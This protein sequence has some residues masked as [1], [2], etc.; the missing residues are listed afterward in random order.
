M[1][2][3]R[4]LYDLSR[5]EPGSASMP[6][7]HG[8]WVLI[9]PSLV[10]MAAGPTQNTADLIGLILIGGCVLGT[11]LV[12]GLRW[13]VRAIEQN[14]RR[15]ES[16]VAQRTAELRESKRQL[17]I[18]VEQ[19][20]HAEAELA[21]RAEQ[22]LHQSEERFRA[23]FESSAIGM[24]LMSLD[25]HFLKANA[26]IRKMSGYAD[27]ELRRL[28]A[29][30]IV[31]PDDLTVGLDLFAEMM[32]GQRDYYQVERRYVRKNGEVFWTRLTLSAV[33][34]KAGAPVYL[35]A[36]VEDID[37][38]K[39]TLL[40]LRKS[41]ARFQAM[42]EN[43]AVGIA[44]ISLDGR[45]LA[46]NPATQQISGYS[47][48]DLTSIN[49]WLLTA[50]EDRGLD[51]ELFA[52]LI[53]GRR[54]SYVVEMRFR[55]KTQG[56][57]WVRV[58]YSL[59][60]DPDGRPDYLIALIENIDEE[61]HAAEKLAAQETEY[62]RELEQRIAARTAELNEANRLLAQQAAQDAVNR[63]RTR[64]A[65]DLHDAVTQTLF[66]ASL[67]A[68]VLPDLWN[69]NQGE[70]LRRLEE[71][72][73]STRG[74]LAEMRTLLVELRPNALVDVPLPDLLRQLTES[75]IGRA[76]LPVQLT[77][78]GRRVLPPEVQLALY[79]ITQEA[80][81]N[82]ARHARASQVIV[83]LRLDEPVR[84]SIVDN[85]T[86]FEPTA[87]SPDHLGTQIL[88]ERAV[89]IGAH[90]ALY[91]APSEGTQITVTWPGS[92]SDE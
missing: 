78:E 46:L 62:R 83:T 16:I 79:R 15:L 61:K 66:S 68:E 82:I 74:A 48:V 22:E 44:L 6:H 54:N 34:D 55:R 17:E 4:Q 86:G 18:E 71:L 59:V 57:G 27:E 39:R 65:R 60:R 58:N 14:A 26:A 70:A 19:R 36:L 20:K 2:Y 90:Y 11:L 92:G 37:E 47:Y 52:D 9:G 31:W 28:T 5:I 12:L 43:A 81:N 32:A 30:D 85:G 88:R 84:L 40:Q 1:I 23:A 33:E 72:R 77:V 75:F 50:D 25:G 21:K 56:V 8:S 67:I 76:R 80:L 49:P 91:S 45:I 7:A 64:L 51:S 53:A 63:E 69:L 3:N 29:E 73:Q 38:Q 41:E 10:S 24:A 13:R 89:A 35:V 87:V 42:F